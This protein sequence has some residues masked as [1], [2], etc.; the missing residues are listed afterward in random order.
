MPDAL[1]REARLRQEH[2]QS[3]PDLEAGAWV[4]AAALARFVLERGLYRK[5]AG[6]RIG[7]RPLPDEHFEFRGPS[8]PPEG[9]P[10][11]RSRETDVSVAEAAQ[12]L[13]SGEERLAARVD[14]AEEQLRKAE[15]L[16]VKAEEPPPQR[17]PEG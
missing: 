14:A 11:G 4:P 2:A 5:V 8:T 15:E 6:A 10:A 1:I 13:R 3:Y 17:P 16:E 12:E 9:R 7:D